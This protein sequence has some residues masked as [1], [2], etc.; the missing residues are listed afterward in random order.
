MSCENTTQDNKQDTPP[1]DSTVAIVRDSVIVKK[2]KPPKPVL[3]PTKIT[4]PPPDFKKIK[5]QCKYINK[6]KFDLQ[7]DRKNLWFNS[8]KKIRTKDFYSLGLHQLMNH[9]PDLKEEYTGYV[10]YAFQ[11]NINGNIGLV[12]GSN[13]DGSSQ[14]TCIIYN[15]Q[16]KHIG[17]A[18]LAGLAADMGFVGAWQSLFKNDSTYQTEYEASSPDK[19]ADAHYQ[20]DLTFTKEGKIVAGDTTF[21]LKPPPKKNN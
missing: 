14:L 2:D 7:E 1:K 20:L 11:E 10:Y 15:K 18:Y 8:Y 16:G 5:T 21:L 4:F 3:T 19:S 17:Q 12:I 6:K 13:P 9:K